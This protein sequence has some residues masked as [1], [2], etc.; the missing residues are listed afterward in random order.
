MKDNK[1][2]FSEF[3]DLNIISKVIK[4]KIIKLESYIISVLSDMNTD[5]NFKE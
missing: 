5:F 2:S 4:E 1:D 3:K